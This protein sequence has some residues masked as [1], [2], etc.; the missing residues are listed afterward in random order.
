MD[1]SYDQPIKLIAV[2]LDGTLLDSEHNVSPRTMSALRAAMARD[3][4][5][6]IATGKTY[7]SATR[8]IDELGITT[9]GVYVQG[10]VI[11]NADGTVRS[12]TTLDP[13]VVRAAADFADAHGI[14]AVA[15]SERRIM[16]RELH[17][18]IHVL[19]G[20]G[21]PLA[22]AVGPLGD[23]AASSPVNKLIFLGAPEQM[24]SA[25]EA[26]AMQLGDKATLVQALAHMLEIL[27]PGAS[28][29]AGVQRLLDELGIAPEN[30]L[31]IGDGEN[32]VEMLQM[33]GIGVAVANAM[34]HALEAA[35]VV[36]A[37][38]DDD[39]AAEAIERFVLGDGS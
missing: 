14:P 6:V 39:G 33:A 31:A 11:H 18:H 23:A 8:I 1:F 38:N 32:D 9:P 5:I 30:M 19:S 36:V 4:Q 28:K 17:E 20:Y 29:G 15:Y 16:C 3:V 37:S 13:A 24:T 12:S 35:N 26:L 21:E 7:D 10:L 27:P 25:R 2:D 34:P 22:E